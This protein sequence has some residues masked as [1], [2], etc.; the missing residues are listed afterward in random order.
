MDKHGK[1]RSIQTQLLQERITHM[2]IKSLEQT[3]QQEA[4]TP[5]KEKWTKASIHESSNQEARP[6]TL[7][8]IIFS[9]KSEV[10]VVKVAMI[11]CASEIRTLR[12]FT[13][14]DWF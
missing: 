5:S 2:H 1:I 10:T 3:L 13:T 4:V 11:L 14:Q 8:D 12:P 9:V 7:A 6:T